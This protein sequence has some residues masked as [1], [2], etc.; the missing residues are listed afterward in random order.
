VEIEMLYLKEVN[1]CVQKIRK[2]SKTRGFG[3]QV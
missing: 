3:N 2:W 1:Q